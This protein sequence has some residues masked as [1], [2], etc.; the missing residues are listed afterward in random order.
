MTRNGLSSFRAVVVYA[1]YIPVALVQAGGQI[2]TGVTGILLLPTV[3]FLLRSLSRGY[4]NA[5]EFP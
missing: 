1:S 4:R 3:R 2:P 5:P